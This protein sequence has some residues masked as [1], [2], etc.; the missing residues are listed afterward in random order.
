MDLNN[1]NRAHQSERER[2]R[3]REIDLLAGAEVKKQTIQFST[4]GSSIF[5]RHSS[6][7]IF[8]TLPF[9]LILKSLFWLRLLFFLVN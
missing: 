7:D 2:E 3:D 8:L 9:L 4:L 5:L 1:L 6:T